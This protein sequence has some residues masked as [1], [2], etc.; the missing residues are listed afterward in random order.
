MVW[1]ILVAASL[2]YFST[3]RQGW[4]G[5]L[6]PLA[7]LCLIYLKA[8]LVLFEFMEVGRGPRGWRTFFEVWLAAVVGL[9]FVFTFV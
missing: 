9:I 1:T 4:S 6:A 7:V 8:R 3:R 2:V 5:S